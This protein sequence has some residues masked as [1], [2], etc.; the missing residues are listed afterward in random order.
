MATA[1]PARSSADAGRE[2]IGVLGGTFDPPHVAHAIVAQDLVEG[3]ALDRL[4]VVPAPD[5]PHRSF[6]LPAATRL[7]LVRRMFEGVSR[8]EVSDLEYGREGPSY[9][10]RTLETLRELHPEA[11]LI[12]VM[13]TDQFAELDT[14]H[15]P[16]R[17][18]ELARIAVMR[19]QGDDPRPP[20]GMDPIE[21]I[22]VHVTRIDLSASRIRERLGAGKSIRFLVPEAIRLDIER[23]WQVR[24]SADPAS[25]E[26]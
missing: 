24:A 14:W 15:E 12:L 18:A 17:L 21:Y 23:A 2:R 22:A 1:D 10:V 25:R 16:G 3:L 11:E 8:I 20:D 13:G 5:P 26:C 4:L 7:E 9:T 6:E 19:R